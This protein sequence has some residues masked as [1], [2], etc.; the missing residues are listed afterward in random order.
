[1]QFT[2]R[3][4]LGLGLLAVSTSSGF[5]QGTSC[6][7]PE[8][9][10]GFGTFAFDT[11]GGT[12]TG[13][14]GA[15][16]P[17]GPLQS[18]G[19]FA[20]TATHD[21]DVR[22][23]IRTVSLDTPFVVYQGGDCTATCVGAATLGQGSHGSVWRVELDNVVTGAVYLIQLGTDNAAGGAQAGVLSVR[24]QDCELGA[25][26]DDG[27]EDN[28][29]CQTARLI[30]AGFHTG[31]AASTAD[32]DFYEVVI[33]PL[34]KLEMGFGSDS[35]GFLGIQTYFGA[36]QPGSTTFGP[37]VRS[38]LSFQPRSLIFQVNTLGGCSQSSLDVRLTPVDCPSSTGMDDA[39]EDNEDCANAALLTPGTYT[40]LWTSLEDPD[41]YQVSVPPGHS[42]VLQVASQGGNLGAGFPDETCFA[43]PFY[44]EQVDVRKGNATDQTQI[45]DFLVQP[46]GSGNGQP[47]GEYDLTV[48]VELDPCLGLGPDVLDALPL[49][50]LDA[51][52][53][54]DGS[55]LGL[56]MEEAQTY[57]FLV[58]PGQTLSIDLSLERLDGT[59]SAELG[60]SPWSSNC[61][62]GTTSG[63]GQQ[64]TV[65]WTNPDTQNHLARLALSYAGGSLRCN[66][67][68]MHV[69]GSGGGPGVLRSTM[70]CDPADPNST[71]EPTNLMLASGVT[72]VYGSREFHASQGPAGQ[73]GYLLVGT[74]ALDPGVVVSQGHLCLDSTGANQ[75]GRY[76]HFLGSAL[77]SLGR[78]DALGRFENLSDTSVGPFGFQLPSVLPFG[79]W[80]AFGSTYSFQLWHRED[81]GASNFSN[82]ITVQF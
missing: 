35:E 65:Q 21:A 60:C 22:L 28:D 33:P 51:V 76:N 58:E 55:H 37:F 64:F 71:G 44:F 73:F 57:D 23:D 79:G 48:S 24:W 77:N 13:F 5:A 62:F 6:G 2:T 70:F 15:C 78:F 7:S 68:D 12:S 36:C 47:C 14:G 4:A 34:H 16:V 20:W 81:G 26:A 75:I 67:F 29:T 40:Q 27:F 8:A 32:P 80:I 17:V 30:G 10:A 39:F 1:M 63:S 59:L 38:N 31:L 54:G 41:Y 50:P 19:F 45:I 18:E 52:T 61:P 46:T 72:G 53:L 66:R 43:D 42:V 3:F 82:G 69:T 56:Y 25:L 9:I 11:T 49:D 74:A